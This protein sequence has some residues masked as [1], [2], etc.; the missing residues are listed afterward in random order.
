MPLFLL[1]ALACA[2]KPASI[3]AQESQLVFNQDR[4]T[5]DARALDKNGEVVADAQVLPTAVADAEVLQLGNEGAMQC[6][7]SGKSKVTLSVAGLTQEIEVTCLLV[8]E[9]RVRPLQIKA[10]LTKGPSGTLTPRTLKAPQAEVISLDDTRIEWATLN[11][12]SSDES[13]ARLKEDGQIE[14]LAPGAADIVVTVGDRSA[15]IPLEVGE[16]VLSRPDLVVADG[17]ET[18]I[19]IE[20]G[21]YRVTATSNE[22]ISL[23]FR[24]TECSTPE[25]RIDQRL[26]CAFGATTTLAVENPGALLRRGAEAKVKLRVVKLPPAEA[27]AAIPG[28]AGA[29]EAE[30]APE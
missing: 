15:R 17:D 13:I 1:A 25:D 19:P 3:E 27:G 26:E 22:P 5:L 16:E 10:V 28:E 2:S 23:S 9:L 21:R 29:P 20:A 4:I 24:Q 14:L 7:K 6:L 11:V 12:K 18:G 30:P 8:K